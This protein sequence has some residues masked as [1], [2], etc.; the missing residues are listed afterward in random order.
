MPR[1]HIAALCLIGCATQANAQL[2][3]YSFAEPF[4]APHE[5]S[6]TCFDGVHFAPDYEIMYF[7]IRLQPSSQPTGEFSGTFVV[8]GDCDAGGSFARS[9]ILSSFCDGGYPNA[10]T[11]SLK[12]AFAED[13]MPTGVPLY[14][15]SGFPE[16]EITVFTGFQPGDSVGPDNNFGNGLL[17]GKSPFYTSPSMTIASRQ[18]MD[19]VGVGDGIIIGIEITETDGVHYGWIEIRRAP[20]ADPTSI[21]HCGER[22]YITRYA[23]ELTPGVPALVTGTPCPADTNGD[24]SLT[25]A[26]FTAW[27]AA[28]NA[29]APECD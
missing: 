22:Y 19:V 18:D 28:F 26:D 5:A 12:F 1:K 3:E 11:N 6:I 20:D 14:G 8:D 13:P 24:G 9:I 17:L 2:Q 27:V 21:D 7:D 25:P 23:Y 29:N 16:S 10:G 4:R 15:L